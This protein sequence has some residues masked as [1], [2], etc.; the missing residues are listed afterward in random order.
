MAGQ[1]QEPGVQ[2]ATARHS[3]FDRYP[4]ASANRL[5]KWEAEALVR[6][7]LTD[8][9]ASHHVEIFRSMIM[10]AHGLALSQ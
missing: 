2:P 3:L 9:V 7:S 10:C 4:Q 5:Q 1:A 8:V 6:P